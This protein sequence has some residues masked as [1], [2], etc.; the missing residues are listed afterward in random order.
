LDKNDRKPRLGD[1]APV[2]GICLVTTMMALVV[3]II[4][5]AHIVVIIALAA[6]LTALAVKLRQG[7]S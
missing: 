2:L 1:V 4:M 6:V 7:S 5:K 3:A